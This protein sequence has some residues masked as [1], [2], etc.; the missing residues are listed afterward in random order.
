MTTACFMKKIGSYI[1]VEQA[2]S[3]KLLAQL[4]GSS[5]PP[6]RIPAMCGPVHRPPESLEDYEA[7]K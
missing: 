7:N 6:C 4:Q 3:K 1:W 5:F 2:I